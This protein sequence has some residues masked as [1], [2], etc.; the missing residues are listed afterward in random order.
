VQTQLLTRLELDEAALEVEL[1]LASTFP[2]VE[3]YTDFQC[4]RRPWRSCMIWSPGGQVGDGVLEGYDAVEPCCPT[5]HGAHLEHLSW[6]IRSTFAVDQLLFVRLVEMSETV[7]VPHRD[8]HVVAH[9]LH[10]PLRT[11][12]EC[13]FM[14]GN[15]VF[16]MLPGEVWSIDLEELHSAVVFDQTRRLHLILDFRDAPSIEG[17]VTLPTTGRT[18]IP[19]DHIVE[20][21]PLSS[22]EE[23]A[24]IELSRVVDADNFTDVFGTVIRKQF[25]RDGGDDLAWRVM[26]EIAARSGDDL[27]RERVRVLD[28]ACTLDP[29]MADTVDEP[30]APSSIGLHHVGVLTRDL[31]NSVAWYGELLGCE[32]AWTLSTFSDLT[33]SRLPGITRLTELAGPRMRI[34]I[35]ERDGRDRAATPA[36][37]TQFQH[38]CLEVE[39]VAELERLRARW[40]ELYRSGHFTFEREDPPS[41]L[42]TDAE[43]VT[44]FYA[45]DVDGLELEFTYEGEPDS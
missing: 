7:L 32:P 1:A 40:F 21:P 29:V 13:L 20:R 42:V 8:R 43:G 22:I 38:L 9:R 23:Q 35:M 17:L 14:E 12:D 41:P 10:V 36:C 25:R 30:P 33:H 18:G 16:R 28:A 37:A 5:P 39:S 19:S 31:D 15:C 3:P 44:S 24:L 26:R 6:L 11:S 45:F 34:H 2:F 27:V 4:G